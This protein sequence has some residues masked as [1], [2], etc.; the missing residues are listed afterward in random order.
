M[1]NKHRIVGY[2][3]AKY[4]VLEDGNGFPSVIDEKHYDKFANKRIYVHNNYSSFSEN[5]TTILVHHCIKPYTGQSIDHINRIPADN[6]EAN[7]RYATQEVQNKNQKKR[8]RNVTFPEDCNIKSES[9]PTFIWYV[10]G[11]KTHGDRFAVQIKNKYIWKTTAIRTLSLK[12]KLE[13]AKKHLRHLLESKPELFEGHS[14]NGSLS[15]EGQKLKQEYIQILQLAG[16]TYTEPYQ[17]DVLE[18]DH[19]GL[20]EVE[21]ESISKLYMDNVRPKCMLPDDCNIKPA[22]IPKYCYYQPAN[23]RSGDFFVCGRKHRKQLDSK[24]EW[25]TTR[26]RSISISEK[27]QQLLQY[28]SS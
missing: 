10:K 19:T 26:K 5:K 22:D 9:I 4:I 13:I 15:A 17:I 1:R 16:Y 27:F 25:C 3:G 23:E 28:V 12:C 24:K 20:N 14:V 18:E 21:I 6:R 2:Q 8:K 7:L 11:D